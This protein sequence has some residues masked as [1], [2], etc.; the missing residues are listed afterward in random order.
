M[1]QKVAIMWFRRDLR[2]EDNAALYHAF[3]QPHPVI[4]LFIF[5]THILD[6]L[7]NRNDARVQFIHSVITNMHRQLMR[8][9]SSMWVYYGSPLQVFQQLSENFSIQ[10]VYTNTDYE[11]YAIVR[12]A[13]I[14]DFLLRQGA[15]FHSF[16]DQVIFDGSEVVKENGKPYTV[17]TPYSRKWKALLQPF[18]LKSYPSGRDIR[19]FFQSAEHTI[20]TLAEMGFHAADIPIPSQQLNEGLIAKY[21]QQRNFPAV[22][23]TSRLGIHLRFGTISIRMLAAK[24]QQLNEVFLN[25]LI[26]RDFYHSILYHFPHVREGKAFKPIYDQIEWS[27]NEA[28][29]EKWCAGKTGYPIVDAGMRELNATGYMHNRV[30]MIV[31]SFLTKHL[32]IDWR[33]GEAYF[34]EKL[35]DYDFAANNGGWQ[36]AAGSGC[37]AAPYFR[38]FNPALQTEKFDKNLAYINKWIPELNSFEYPDPIVQHEMAR[39]RALQ[40]YGAVL[41]NKKE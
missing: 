10:S 37:D 3:R 23:G 6:K 27:N 9:G 17:F 25:E 39:K 34:A 5:D 35:L 18:H 16:K 1:K 29:F 40:V 41:K 31:A 12:D 28:A 19:Y 20:P 13:G 7:T 21:N 15:A 33:W 30:R 2:F 26:W 8:N 14:A 24:A 11:Q 4:P 38:I 32:L 36:W 22:N